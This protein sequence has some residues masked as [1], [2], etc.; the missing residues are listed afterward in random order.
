MKPSLSPQ[1]IL[2]VALGT[3]VPDSF[4]NL[5]LI[6]AAETA[7]RRKWSSELGELVK[8]CSNPVLKYAWNSWSSRLK[9]ESS[10]AEEQ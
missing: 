3:D 1:E 7:R 6:M 10:L 5:L 2:Q 9:T 8:M 4:K